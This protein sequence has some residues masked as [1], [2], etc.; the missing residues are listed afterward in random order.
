VRLEAQCFL[1]RY[2]DVIAEAGPALEYTQEHSAQAIRLIVLACLA[3]VQ[4]DRG[5]ALV[6]PDELADLGRRYG[7]GL[8]VAAYV[9]AEQGQHSKAAPLLREYLD[10]PDAYPPM[11]AACVALAIGEPELLHTI[12][13][14][15]LSRNTRG[16]AS[17]Q[18]IA[19]LLAAHQ[20]HP[21]EGARQLR[22]AADTFET[23]GMIPYQVVA[24]THLGR[25]LLTLDRADEA[26][27]GLDQA[28][29]LATRM[30]ATH[31]IDEILGLLQEIEPQG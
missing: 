22:A 15:P 20:G 16:E 6:D 29:E 12:V 1:G 30:R 31:R 9:Y 13:Q 21:E 7:V 24:L 26:R 18:A 19:G 4:I 10:Q 27:I 25:C 11:T 17:R 2:D 5:E 8:D 14:R 23:I 3:A 28:L